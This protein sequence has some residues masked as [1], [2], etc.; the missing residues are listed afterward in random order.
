LSDSAETTPLTRRLRGRGWPVAALAPDPLIGDGST[1]TRSFLDYEAA[2][3]MHTIIALC[4]P[5]ILGIAAQARLAGLY[6]RPEQR[7]LLIPPPDSGADRLSRTQA[8]ERA[9]LD[10][11]ARESAD[12]VGEPVMPSGAILPGEIAGDLAGWLAGLPN[13]ISDVGHTPVSIGVVL[14]HRDRPHPAARALDSLASQTRPPDALAVVDAASTDPAAVGILREAVARFRPGPACLLEQDTPSLG[15]ARAAGAA[16][17][18]TGWLLFMDDDN[19]APPEALATFA[20]AAATGRADIWTCW[21]RLFSVGH[22]SA[23]TMEQAPLY[24]PLGPVPG[25]MARENTLGDAN[26][27]I[28]TEAFHV[29]GGFD[30]DPTIGA[31]DW[32]LLVRAWIAGVRHRVIPRVLL[33]KRQ[34][35]GSMSATMDYARARARIAG[36]LRGAGIPV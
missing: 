34:S 17:L 15:A 29:L 6:D 1:P 12:W 21:A 20:R 8:L 25:L 27:L 26:L 33:W 7:L 28:R 22:P 36:R 19:I 13:R 24:A 10:H 4:P 9:A 32:D 3:A 18:G 30:P 11:L 5:W 35:A 2:T 14:V 23:A 16:A 31:E